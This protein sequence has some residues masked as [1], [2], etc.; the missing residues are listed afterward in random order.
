MRT[1]EKTMNR[2]RNR[3]LWVVGLAAWA[4]PMIAAIPARAATITFETTEGYS[5]TGGTTT[6]VKTSPTA[7]GALVGQ[8]SGTGVTKWA[9][10][11]NSNDVVTITQDPNNNQVATTQNSFYNTGLGRVISYHLNASTTNLSG[12]YNSS[13]SILN[14]S[15]DLRLNGTP[16]TVAANKIVVRPRISGATDSSNTISDFELESDGLFAYAYATNAAGG[17]GSG[18]KF[19]T[20]DGS[21]SSSSTATANF[22]ATSG[23]FFTVSGTMNFATGT[24]WSHHTYLS[25][26]IN[27]TTLLRT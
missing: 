15:F 26:R 19:A 9:G 20:K 22:I 25:D 1:T 4:A 3:G 16:T 13:S 23:K 24:F 18:I 11:G 7:N 8:P 12:T 6:G 5:T 27:T 10:G 21:L 2:A 17:T 14:Y